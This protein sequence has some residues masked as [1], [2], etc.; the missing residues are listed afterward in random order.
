MELISIHAY[1]D[2]NNPFDSLSTSLMTVSVS[3]VLLRAAYDVLQFTVD[4]VSGYKNSII[5][6]AHNKENATN[7]MKP[8]FSDLSHPL[9]SME[10]TMV[11]ETPSDFRNMEY[12]L[13]HWE[14][15][16]PDK[17]TLDGNPWRSDEVSL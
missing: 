15:L 17:I 3:L 2:E 11:A 10:A 9:M 6:E 7:L 16:E 5:E 8:T 1:D 4:V 13:L 12:N 14:P